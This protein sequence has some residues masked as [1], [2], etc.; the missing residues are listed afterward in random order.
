M[1]T[2]HVISQNYLILAI[3]E[4]QEYLVTFN[5]TDEIRIWAKSEDNK[6]VPTTTFKEAKFSPT[7]VNDGW[8][9]L[10][11]WQEKAYKSSSS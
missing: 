1:R 4:D 11:A 3:S 7:I 5:F 9:F 8:N 6:Y 2:L 10:R